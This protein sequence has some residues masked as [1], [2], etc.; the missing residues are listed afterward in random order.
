[1]YL[2]IT[3]KARRN[4]SAAQR[5]LQ[6]ASK[7]FATKLN[8]CPQSLPSWDATLKETLTIRKLTALDLSWD[9]TLK[10]N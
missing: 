9:V 3:A 7:T 1:V 6:Q 10:A 2:C 8:N 5:P 4:Y